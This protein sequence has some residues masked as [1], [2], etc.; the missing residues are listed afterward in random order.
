[1]SSFEPLLPSLLEK[2]GFTPLGGGAAPAAKVVSGPLRELNPASAQD[3]AAAGALR[4][5]EERALLEQTAYARGVAEGRG[6]AEAQLAHL[7]QG[8]G[9]AIA[10]LT[11]FRH[12]TLT[13]YQSELLDLALEVARKVVDRELEQHP[14]HW[15]E[16]IREGVRRAVDRD[17][18]RVRVAAPLHAFLRERLA[19]L[20]GALEGV[21]DLELLE[22]PALPPSGCVIETSY[23]D[24]DLGV[25]SQ[26]ATIRGA[27]VEPA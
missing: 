19:E 9:E 27:M 26:I 11:R 21:K 6:Q 1:M 17:H 14:E 16:L 18:I 4:L 23:G 13:R 10:E 25:G 15:I 7:V 22:D 3:E 12:E 2:L 20:C 24:L 5:A 8:M